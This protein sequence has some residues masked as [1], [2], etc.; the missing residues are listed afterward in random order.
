V[1]LKPV[2]GKIAPDRGNM[3]SGRLLSAAVFAGGPLMAHRCRRAAAV[4]PARHLNQSTT[5]PK[6]GYCHGYAVVSSAEIIAVP[7]DESVNSFFQLRFWG[8]T[9]QSQK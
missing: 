3:H 1:N 4:H 7:R 8:K 9:S 6:P 5:G 2:L